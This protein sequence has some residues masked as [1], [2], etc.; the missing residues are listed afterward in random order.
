MKPHCVSKRYFTAWCEIPSDEC[1]QWYFDN[2]GMNSSLFHQFHNVQFQK[3]F[4]LCL[5]MGNREIAEIFIFLAYYISQ[6]TIA[7][8]LSVVKPTILN[9]WNFL[10]EKTTPAQLLC[11]FSGKI[12]YRQN[13]QKPLLRTRA[14]WEVSN[15]SV[16]SPIA[17]QWV[18]T[19]I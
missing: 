10:N 18:H 1:I 16:D 7:G 12:F 4:T 19:V 8:A 13:Y 14:I 5:L 9:I 3:I 2:F 11:P 6:T 17:V 15:T